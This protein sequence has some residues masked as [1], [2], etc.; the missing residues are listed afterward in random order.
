[1]N[2]VAGP[3]SRVNDDDVSEKP[4]ELAEPRLMLGALVPWKPPT[5]VESRRN[6]DG[7]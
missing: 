2:G 6:G 4:D 5:H 1:L 3:E 7:G